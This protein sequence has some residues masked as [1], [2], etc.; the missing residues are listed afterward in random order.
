MRSWNTPALLAAMG[1]C[2]L[3]SLFAQNPLLPMAAGPTP[4]DM[5]SPEPVLSAPQME[6]MA[7]A[8]IYPEAAAPTFHHESMAYPLPEESVYGGSPV[9]ESS[10]SLGCQGCA[11]AAPVASCHDCAEPAL[12]ST[13]NS[14]AAPQ[15]IMA[16]PACGCQGGSSDIQSGYG[17]MG[18]G[19]VGY[20]QSLL[21]GSGSGVASGLLSPN[22]NS[23]YI[24][25]STSR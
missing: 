25:A 12:V 8:H 7:P 9:M 4:V 24:L 23:G 1:L 16:A 22:A 17:Q 21:M 11:D 20:G 15:Q 2:G 10:S 19:Q 3:G 18:Y 5:P 6:P 14:C 13:C